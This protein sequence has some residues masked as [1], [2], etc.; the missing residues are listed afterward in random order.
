[1]TEQEQ[2]TQYTIRLALCFGNKE[3]LITG[4]YRSINIY[5]QSPGA[6]ANNPTVKQ[7]IADLTEIV[8]FA[9]KQPYI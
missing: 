7:R 2:Q 5:Y 8:Q 1:M 6:K 3:V 4:L 9:E